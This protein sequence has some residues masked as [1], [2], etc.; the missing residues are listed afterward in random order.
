MRFRSAAPRQR[1]GV[2][3]GFCA[4]V[5]GGS[6]IVISGGE[7]VDPSRV[8]ACGQ[9]PAAGRRSL[10][11][12]EGVKKTGLRYGGFLTQRRYAS[13][14]RLQGPWLQPTAQR[15]KRLDDGEQDNRDQDHCRQ[16]V[17]QAVES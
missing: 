12:R 5:P 14:T 13:Q 6:S 15:S 9:N 4:S 11:C 10:A 2:Q 3:R 17:S 16:F 1:R 8:A 7:W